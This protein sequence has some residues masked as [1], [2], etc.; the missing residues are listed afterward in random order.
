MKKPIMAVIL[1]SSLFWPAVA[2]AD[3]NANLR[4]GMYQG[5]SAWVEQAIL[6]GANPNQSVPY[7]NIRISALSWAANWGNLKL[8]KLLLDKGADPNFQDGSG[9]PALKW[10]VAFGNNVEVVKLLI[11]KGANLY[12]QDQDGYTVLMSATMG[13]NLPIIQYLIEKGADIHARNKTG[14]TVLMAAAN[15]GHL[16]VIHYLIKKGAVLNAQDDLGRTAMTEAIWGNHLAVVR[17]Y[18][19]HANDPQALEMAQEY[20]SIHHKTDVLKLLQKYD[21]SAIRGEQIEKVK[22]WRLNPHKLVKSEQLKALATALEQ[23][24]KALPDTPAVQISVLLDG[25]D[26][27]HSAK[28]KLPSNW[29][30]LLTV[31]GLVSFKTMVK[32]KEEWQAT[33]LTNRDLQSVKTERNQYNAWVINIELTP[34]AAKQMAEITQKHL[35]EQMGIFLDGKLLSSPKIQSVI[36]K[37]KVLIEGNFS[38]QEAEELSQSMRLQPLPLPL[39]LVAH[40]E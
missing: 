18:L 14:Y 12:P 37:G 4:Q 27:T 33:G 17:Y 40:S 2:W 6:Q 36:A 29:E 28:A 20:A 30:T 38:Q 39:T 21:R 7:H 19:D 13:G 26:V 23:R 15:Q 22:H 5:K 3:A 24:L 32:E 25:L 1:T 8:V 16:E 31:Q 9:L 10:A 34:Q 11:A 35:G